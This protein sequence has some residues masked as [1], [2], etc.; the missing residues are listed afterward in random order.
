MQDPIQAKVKYPRNQ[1]EAQQ[2]LSQGYAIPE[3]WLDEI[4]GFTPSMATLNQ[5]LY[6]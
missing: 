3:E 4:S 5:A 2:L 1:Q 6:Q